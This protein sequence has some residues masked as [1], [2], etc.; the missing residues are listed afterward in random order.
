[1]LSCVS[2]SGECSRYA[3]NQNAEQA[4]ASCDGVGNISGFGKCL[5]VVILFQNPVKGVESEKRHEYLKYG[6]GHGHCPELVVER[7]IFEPQAGEPHEM[8]APCEH[9][10]NECRNCHPPF[11]ASLAE[12]ETED[13]KENG[14][15]SHIHRTCCKRLRTPVERHVLHGLSQI[16]LTCPL[17]QL[18]GLRVHGKFSGR[19]TS[20]EVRDEQVWHFLY[21]VRP[22]CG[23]SEV[24]A[25]VVVRIAV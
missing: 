25:L 5:F 14:D 21:A 8:V 17:E 10:G 20:V 7:G 3:R 11:I 1:M 22:C 12:D 13:E 15:C 23:I 24:K 6:Q 19:R 16:R 18:C 2:R 4:E 9:Y